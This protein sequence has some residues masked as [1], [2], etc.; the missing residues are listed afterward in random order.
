MV[1]PQEDGL[2][3]QYRHLFRC[4]SISYI[5]MAQTVQEAVLLR[6]KRYDPTEQC[7]RYDTASLLR[8]VRERYV[9]VAAAGDGS[10]Y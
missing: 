4:S 8:R 1:A 2:T 5:W 9:N 3:G 6:P 7:D 10:V